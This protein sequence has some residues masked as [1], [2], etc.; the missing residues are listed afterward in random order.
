MAKITL[1]AV[2]AAQAE[3]NVLSEKAARSVKEVKT[4]IV[5][6][7]RLVGEATAARNHADLLKREFET[8]SK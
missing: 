3:A 2:L 4:G 6:R 1:D 7:D 8:Q 5:R